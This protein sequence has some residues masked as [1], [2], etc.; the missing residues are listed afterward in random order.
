MSDTSD[1]L[2]LPFILPSQA[3]KHVTH[4]EALVRLDAL[5]QMVFESAPTNTPPAVPNAGETWATGAAPTD[6]WAGQPNQ[7]AQWMAPGWLFMTPQEGWRAWLRDTAQM[8]VWD[9][10]AWVAQSQT[11]NLDGIGIG[12]SW[13]ATN[14][15]AVASDASLLSHAGQ[16]HQLKIN[17]A[18][19]SDTASLLYQTNWTGHAEMGLA[20]DNNFAIKVSPDGSN[21]TDAVVVDAASGTLSGAGVQASASDRTPGKLAQAQHSYG[22]D[23]VVGA[24]S[25]S[26][27]LPTGA[28]V[29]QGSNAGGTYVRFADGTQ[30]CDLRGATLAY[31]AVGTLRTTWVFPAAF[32]GMEP[33][34][35]CSFSNSNADFIDVGWADL[36]ITRHSNGLMSATVDV[37]KVAGAPNFIAT[38]E[39]RDVRLMAVGRWF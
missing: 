11:Q 25:Q 35:T 32:A 21:W 3:Q 15:L 22:P 29:E 33:V 13:D 10:S 12:T 34:I 16:G 6:G 7:I 4:N 28:V 1:R 38:S 20:G 31:L 17:K 27:G 9:G 5:V 18:G 37:V 30:I 26:G 19:V 39:V 14:R 24:V 8:V 2:D 36:G 23:N